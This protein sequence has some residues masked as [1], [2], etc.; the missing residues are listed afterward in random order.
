MDNLPLDGI[1]VVEMS[2]MVMGPTC[3]LILGQLGA[4]VIKVEPLYGDK[5]RSLGGMGVS[6]FP[7]FNRGKKS[8]AFNLK[9]EKGHEAL[10]RLLATADVFIENFKDETISLLGLDSGSLVKKFPG[11]IIGA[12]KGFL[13]GPY[14]H[15][16]AL[17]E[18]VQMMSG[19]AYMTGLKDRPLR[20]GS[21]MNDIM[22]GIFGVVG[23]LAALIAKQQSGK[24]KEI[25]IGLFENSLFSV[26]QHMVQYEMTGI[27]P[28][29]MS[30][31][32]HAW[33]IYDI[34]KTA[35]NQRIFIGV[36]TEGNWQ[37]FCKAFGFQNFLCDTGLQTVTD[38]INARSR[39]LPFIA[40][41]MKLENIVTLEK[42][43][44]QLSIP[45][46]KINTPKDM[47]DD[48]HV[49][50]PGGLV[51][52]ETPDGTTLKTPSLPMEIDRQTVVNG[53]KIPALGEHTE[54]VLA[55]LGYNKSEII[56]ITK[57]SDIQ[58]R[59]E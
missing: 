4:E 29:P 44:D 15:R 53:V 28:P 34:F 7:I 13:S 54:M 19:L 21:S 16:P 49:L 39:T 32:V 25:R 22:G 26:A 3:G 36:T 58:T 59:K 10:M 35:D 50:R 1:R 55:D 5:T 24:G 12:H 48:P 31:R 2:H 56:E 20:V 14:E 6:F 40:A 43:L 11:L 47:F 37:A 52:M 9:T 27:A 23:I 17:D 41:R 30:E 8:V 46:S 57:Q 42:T 33:P 45:F 51:T 38:R 18:V